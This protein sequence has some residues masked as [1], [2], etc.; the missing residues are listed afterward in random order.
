MDVDDDKRYC[1]HIQ[2]DSHPNHETKVVKI[3]F[4]GQD[5][6]PVDDVLQ[7]DPHL[8]S[9]NSSSRPSVQQMGGSQLL[10]CDR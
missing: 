5:R 4:V 2:I 10:H 9:G 8:F 3:P 7:L 1:V 6:P